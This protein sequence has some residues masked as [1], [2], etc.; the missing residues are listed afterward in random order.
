LRISF[1][2]LIV[3]ALLF[4]QVAS[5]ASAEIKLK[6]ALLKAIKTHDTATVKAL[7][8]GDYESIDNDYV[9]QEKIYEYLEEER[10]REKEAKA[11]ALAAEK[12]AKDKAKAEA[13]AQDNAVKA[14]VAASIAAEEAAKNRKKQD[15]ILAEKNSKKKKA[16]AKKKA[17]QDTI[18]KRKAEKQAVAAVLAAKKAADNKKRHDATAA[19]EKARLNALAKEEASTKAARDDA[20]VKMA[21]AKKKEKDAAAKKARQKKAAAKKR[22]DAAAKKKAAAKKATPKKKKTAVVKPKAAAAVVAVPVV[23]ASKAPATQ[24]SVT[25]K[26]LV[27]LWK[28]ISSE[29]VIT[30]SVKA[31]TSFMLEQVEDDGTL[32][33]MGNWK[34]EENI[35]MLSIKKVQRNVHTRDT[36]IHRIYKVDRLSKHRLVLRDKRNRIAYDLKR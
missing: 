13:I 16:A 11:K 8:G 6:G 18:A 2:L 14:A 28:Q 27:G 4:T 15:T 10:V 1:L 22:K 29:K 23:A 3:H 19:K 5:A 20:A 21:A 34:H 33:I 12:A 25:A 7:A 9:L 35:F 32:T 31:D 17:E 26:E 36:N 24:L 30:L